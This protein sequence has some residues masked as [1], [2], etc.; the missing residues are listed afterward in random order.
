[1]R[2]QRRNKQAVQARENAV[3]ES[4][5]KSHHCQNYIGQLEQRKISQ[6]ANKNSDQKQM[7][8]PRAGKR[9]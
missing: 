5:L 8:G 2:F 6:G 3:T 1:M 7:S 4:R 9:G